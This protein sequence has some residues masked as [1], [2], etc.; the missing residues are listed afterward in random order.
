M[1]KI[2]NKTKIVCT[3]GPA[4]NKVETMV[5]MAKAGMTVARLNF[6]HGTYQ[7]HEIAIKNIR[8]ASRIVG[9][10]LGIL[11]DLCG[12]KIRIGELKKP[13]ELNDGDEIEISAKEIVGDRQKISTN[14]ENLM[15]DIK[16][17]ET[18]L[19]DDG[20]ISLEIIGKEKD[21][22]VCKT[23][24]G[25]LV[26]PKKGLNFP[27]SNLSVTAV[28]DK[29]LQDVDFGIKQQVDFFALSFVRKASDISQLKSY[30]LRKTKPIPVV[31][32]VEKPDAIN[33]LDN[34]ITEADIVMV[35]RGDLGVEMHTEDVPILQ[36]RIIRKCIMANTPVIT[37]TQMLDSMINNPRPTRAEASDVANAVFDGTDAVMLSG[38]TSVGN[39][40]VETVQVMDAIIKRTEKSRSYH[41][42]VNSMNSQF[43]HKAVSLPEHLAKAACGIAEDANAKAV[44]VITKSGSS[45][46]FLS[47]YRPKAPIIALTEMEGVIGQLNIVCNVHCEKIDDISDTDSTFERALSLVKELGYVNSGDVVVLIG[48]IPLLEVKEVN[49]VKALRIK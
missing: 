16:V 18:L 41:L 45:A 1:S 22:L 20:L 3:I 35:A 30:I 46:R 6:S 38:E 5:A 15:Q 29:D 47:K 10:R 42:R 19:I 44:M 24:H 36:K 21:Y 33:D 37:A 40:P 11:L 28:T 17:G 43:E 34:I 48:G 13:F 23:V 27:G 31:A 26:K 9:R 8:K 14:Y 4:T 25:G 39:F 7:D 32:K 49:M 2:L 12:P